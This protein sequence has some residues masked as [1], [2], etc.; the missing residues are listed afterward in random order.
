MV[1]SLCVCACVAAAT[2]QLRN[3][4]SAAGDVNEFQVDCPN[5]ES[6]LVVR[7][8]APALRYLSACVFV[9]V[10]ECFINRTLRVFS[11]PTI[12]G[13]FVDAVC[14]VCIH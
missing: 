13:I 9:D 1:L 12:S 10:R 3:K 4:N 14:A 7:N 2:P 5:C 11:A 8:V 6:T